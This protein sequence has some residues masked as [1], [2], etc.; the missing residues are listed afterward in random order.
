MIVTGDRACALIFSR[1]PWPVARGPWPVARVT[2]QRAGQIGPEQYPGLLAHLAAVPDPRNPRGV[3]HGLVSLLAVAVCAVLTGAKSAAAIG[4]WAAEAPAEVLAALGVRIDPWSGAAPARRGH[5]AAAA[6]RRRRR[7]PRHRDRR[8]ATRP[9]PVRAGGGAAHP[10]RAVAGG[11][12][13][14]QDPARLRAGRL[15]GPPARGGR[16]RQP[17]RAGPGAGRRQEQRDQ[18][19]PAAAR[20]VGP[21]PHGS[22]RGRHAHPSSSTPSTSSPRARP[23]SPSSSA[24]SPPAPAPQAAAVAASAGR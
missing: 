24:T 3:R 14:W 10:A 9:G 19:V 11:G 6:G 16:P 2:A 12:G 17:G 8:L 13:G 22:D 4:A 5:A 15:P 20:A 1:G 21:A 23:T 7:C 18:R